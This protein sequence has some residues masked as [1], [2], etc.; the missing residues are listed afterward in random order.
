LTRF[1]QVVTTLA[2][3]ILLAPV[4]IG[5]ELGPRTRV[6]ILNSLHASVV[7]RGGVAAFVEEL[8][9]LGYM[10]GVNLT[11]DSRNADDD[12]ARLP[13]LAREL[14]ALKPDVILTAGTV[15]ATSAAMKATSTIPIVFVHAIDPVRTGLVAS[16]ARPTGNVTGVTSLNADL[17]AKRL[18]L[19][20]EIAP[21][22]RRIA[23]IVTPVDPE[24]QP[25]LQAVGS[26]ARAR[27]VQL[28][29]LEIKDP[30]RLTSVISDA[31][32]AGARALLVLG[33]PPLYGLSQPLAQLA[34]K[35]RLPAVSAWQEFAEKGGLASYGTDI[36]EVF[37]RAAGMVDRIAKGA[38]PADLP[39]EQPTKFD[40]VVNL[41]TAK[42][43]GLKIPEPILLRANHVVR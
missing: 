15:E 27:R 11:I 21:D 8:R 19:I 42:A 22:V 36:Q 1:A 43:L 3:G 5:A 24:T 40:L 4:A 39:V 34:L 17:G 20:T 16:L 23:V 12:A 2:I 29:V 38:K 37:Q 35:Q 33:S 18:E 14:I 41:K 31:T 6:A 28:D 32:K 30:A 10:E 7:A 9:R 13:D 26:A 25:M